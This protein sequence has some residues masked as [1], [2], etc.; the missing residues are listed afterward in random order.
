MTERTHGRLAKHAALAAVLALLLPAAAA[1]E[2]PG[3]SGTSFTFTARADRISIPDGGSIL[4][5]GYANGTSRAQL[6]GPTLIVDQ[7]QTIP[8]TLR[9][10][11]PAS[12]G[13]NVSIVFP[14]QDMVTATCP[15]G[16]PAPGSGCV[17]GPLTKEAEIGGTVTYTFRAAHAGTFMYH[18]GSNV[19]LQV[20]MGLTGA[21]IVRPAGFNPAAPTAY[22]SA[23][24]AYDREFLFFL[25][26][27]DPR[28]HELIDYRGVQTVAT[29][30]YLS[31]YFPN[32]WFL[33]GRAAPDT[34]SLGG[35]D[36]F[37]TQPYDCQP[38]MHPGER[39]LMRVVGGGQDLH[40]FHHHGNHALVIA[41]DGRPLESAAGTG[42]LAHE[43]FTITSVPGQTVDA[44]FEWTGRDLGWDIYGHQPGDPLEQHEFAP[45]HG[46]PF[47][48][49]LPSAQELT[50]G[51]WYSGMPFLGLMGSLP[52][53]SGGMNPT[54]GFAYMWHSH[55]EK[56]LTNF[57]V[58]PGGMFTMLIIEHPSV[59]IAGR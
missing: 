28:I 40:P 31:D 9:N 21:I 59:P 34:M 30:T 25:T 43:V 16:D 33:N 6:P 32:Y 58:F 54:A 13:Q 27:M 20:E 12:T 18:S 3:L 1:A 53:G 11:L 8:I 4:I 56:E 26:E 41:R 57:D 39:L 14:G 7:G 29:S 24:S 38:R 51:G 17:N 35:T 5:W 15:G 52:P 49:Q 48:V 10:Q 22:G 46:K 19:Q 2:I 36:L 44:I 50:F 55:T 45:D 47:P 23:A 37:P 42:D